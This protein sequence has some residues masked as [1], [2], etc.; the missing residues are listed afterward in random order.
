MT[1]LPVFSRS[2]DPDRSTAE[3]RVDLDIDDVAVLDAIAIIES[4]T[5]KALVA[6]AVRTLIRKRIA[7]SSLLLRMAGRNPSKVD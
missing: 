1:A 5:R 6:D 2:A 7:D 4:T 3:V